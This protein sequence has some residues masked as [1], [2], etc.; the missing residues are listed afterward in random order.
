MKEKLM[1]K[2]DEMITVV[3]RKTIF[4]DEAYQFDGFKSIQDEET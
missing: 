1:S 4:K 2:F 3:S